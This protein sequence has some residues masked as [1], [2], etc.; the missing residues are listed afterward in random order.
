MSKHED[1]CLM[2]SGQ[3]TPGKIPGA[4]F[5]SGPFL[6]RKYERRVNIEHNIKQNIYTGMKVISLIPR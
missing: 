3:L 2:V 6:Y 5:K 4:R 1:Y